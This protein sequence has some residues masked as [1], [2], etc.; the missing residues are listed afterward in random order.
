M[1][2]YLLAI[3]ILMSLNVSAQSDFI[4]DKDPENGSVVFKGVITYDD[5]LSEKTFT[6]LKSGTDSYKPDENS[7][8]YL[9]A[10]LPQYKMVVFLGT[11]CDDSQSMI[12]KLYKILQLTNYPMKNYTMYGVDRTKQA[13]FEEHKI[14][15]IQN[16]PTIILFRDRFEVGRIVETLHKT[17]EADL[18]SIIAADMARK[19]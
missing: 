10:H 3:A 15:N 5:L 7:I 6:W 8:K 17:M 2:K 12:P 9:A 4:T 14:Y 19:Q 18:I 11:W 16:V 13:N 1:K